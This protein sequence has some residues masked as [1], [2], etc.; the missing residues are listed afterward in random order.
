MA[1]RLQQELIMVLWRL[2]ASFMYTQATSKSMEDGVR[3]C[4]PEEGL[5]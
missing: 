1:L 3:V 4:K 2:G 5:Q